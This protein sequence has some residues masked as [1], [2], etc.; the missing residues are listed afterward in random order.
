M[1]LD[2]LTLFPDWFDW[3]RT[4]RHVRNALAQGHEIRTF[5]PRASTPLTGAYYFV[6]SADDLLA[7]ASSPF[8]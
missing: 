5:D 2:V 7:F 8:D 6:P 1:Q 4:Q 3:F